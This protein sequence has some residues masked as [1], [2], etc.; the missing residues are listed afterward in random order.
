MVDGHIHNKDLFSKLIKP[1]V[2]L[3]RIENE[4]NGFDDLMN[5]LGN[6]EGLNAIHL[7]ANSQQGK[8]LLG[9]QLVSQTTIEN[10]IQAF[11]QYN[12][13][14]KEGRELLIYN[15]QLENK[16]R[17]NNNLEI[18]TGKA[19]PV[20]LTFGSEDLVIEKG[21]IGVTPLPESIAL[22]DFTGTLQFSGTI[23]FQEIKNAR[24]YI[25]FGVSQNNASFYTSASKE[26]ALYTTGSFYGTG[27]FNNA[28]YKTFAGQHIKK[29]RILYFYVWNKFNN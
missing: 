19:K 14:I 16:N 20:V 27:T 25:T 23:N 24:D 2:E 17:A 6:Y 29:C 12:N 5:K 28:L 21:D 26:N 7:F 3:F 18:L 8:I 11:N 15:T 13:T 1:G 4:V 10:S 22:K 9:N